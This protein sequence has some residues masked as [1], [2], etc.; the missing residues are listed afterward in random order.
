[1]V[2]RAP[3]EPQSP[4]QQAP[5][6]PQP[7]QSPIDPEARSATA[8]VPL[9]DDSQRAAEVR[10]R[11]SA[12]ARQ[13]TVA[14]GQVAAVMARSEPHMRMPLAE[15]R[16]LVAPAIQ[17]GQFMLASKRSATSGII[18]PAAAVMW[19]RVSDAIDQQLT[20][21]TKAVRLA[22]KAWN[23][24]D[25]LWLM[26]AVGDPALVPQLIERLGGQEWKGKTVKIRSRQV[27]GSVAVHAVGPL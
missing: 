6:L 7:A 20:Q 14:F 2:L 5:A 10:K 15:L 11:R 26:E 12:I 22:P 3:A 18:V 16:W 19:A 9:G 27:D 23:S 25:N 4:D 17:S 13:R 8:S 24:G 21:A 1:M